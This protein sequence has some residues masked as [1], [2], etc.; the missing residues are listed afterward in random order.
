MNVL[1]T[2]GSGFIGSHV[3]DKLVEQG[4]TVRVFDERKPF[5]DNIEWLK[6]N[7]LNENEV[8][9]ACK[10]VEFVYHLAA[11]AD[12]NIALSH[13]A[14]CLQVNEIGTM[15]LLNAASAMEVE[16][17]LLASTT[18]VYGKTEG[19]VDENTP[20]PP[21]DHIY[22]KTKIGQEHLFVA[23]QKQTGLPYTILRYDIPY[24]PRMRANMA[25]AMFVRKAMKK[26]P[27]TI[28]GDGNQGRCFIY[29]DDLASGS[30]AALQPTARNQVF[31]IAGVE[32]ITMN[33]IAEALREN[34]KNL[35]V[36]HS[37]PRPHD[38]KGVVVSIEKVKQLLNWEPKTM[39]REGLKKFITHMKSQEV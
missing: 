21:P 10:D 9:E 6:G 26:E 3:V 19:M 12:V 20:I 30:I 36:E 14:L 18:W 31:N 34:F 24:G 7:L 28:F 17:V 33:K 32:F 27:I 4:C 29:I 38:F 13:P 25:I 35:N 11:I 5:R 1:V 15:N 22:T 37:P 2:G 16:R 23:W 8:L 39:F